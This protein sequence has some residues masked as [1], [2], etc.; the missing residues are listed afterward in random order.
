MPTCAAAS[1]R[2]VP[3]ARRRSYSPRMGWRPVPLIPRPRMPA[4]RAQ[5][6]AVFSFAPTFRAAALTLPSRRS[7]ALKNSSLIASN[8]TILATP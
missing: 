4:L 3:P 8:D 2:V 6:A 5:P 1:R 7:S